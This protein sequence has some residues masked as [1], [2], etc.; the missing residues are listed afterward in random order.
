MYYFFLVLLIDDSLNDEGSLYYKEKQ[1]LL[2]GCKISYDIMNFRKVGS[3]DS[4]TSDR[5][6]SI[7][8][9]KVG[10]SEP[11]KMSEDF[12]KLP[13]FLKFSDFSEN[14]LA[15]PK[16]CEFFLIKKQKIIF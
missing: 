8:Q 13:T 11:Q 2:N 6:H 12:G 4:P 9:K 3:S 5:F 7:P 15:F 14:I 1:E 10:E 16:F